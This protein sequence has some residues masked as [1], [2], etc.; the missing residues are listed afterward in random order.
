M[1]GGRAQPLPC[2]RR[3][4]LEEFTRYAVYAV[5]EGAL[6]RF[7]AQWL[8]WD[9][10]A[11]APCAHPDDLALPRPVSEITASARRYGFH[12]TLKPPFHLAEGMRA[13]DLAERLETLAA[14]TA[15]ATV[16]G[17]ALRRLGAFLALMPE[18]GNGAL[19]PL[20]DA[21]VAGLD[22][23]RAPPGAAEMARRTALPL[24]LSQ[25]E[26]LA[27]W[28]YPY[29]MEE[30]RFHI[31]LTGALPDAEAEMVLDALAP[32]IAP[33][34]PVPYVVDTLCLC[35]EGADGHFRLVHRYPL[36]G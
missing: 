6:G 26:M 27:R 16:P 9:I 10:A 33:L 13:E 12:A 36:A 22:D 34:L 5:P 24:N 7:G 35:G 1:L 8:G 18:G 2:L 31:T 29:V 17:L 32:R 19:G 14:R 15:P 4:I 21:V 30:F 3:D 28:G 20:A 11:G 23:F 25:H